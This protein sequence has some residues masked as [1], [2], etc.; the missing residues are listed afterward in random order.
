VGLSEEALDRFR[1]EV[2]ALREEMEDP[3]REPGEVEG[4]HNKGWEDP[5]ANSTRR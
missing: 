1:Q 3:E 4:R 2:D 5:V